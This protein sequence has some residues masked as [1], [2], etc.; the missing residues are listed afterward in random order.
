MNLRER[1]KHSHT[2]LQNRTKTHFR[3]QRTNHQQ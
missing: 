2:S 1:K 3:I